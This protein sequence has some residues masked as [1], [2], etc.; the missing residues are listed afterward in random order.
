[1]SKNIITLA[2]DLAMNK[3]TD[4]SVEDSNEVLRRAFYDLLGMD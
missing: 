2:N 3:V 4:Y 1:M